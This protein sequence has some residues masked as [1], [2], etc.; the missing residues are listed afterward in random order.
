MKIMK[1]SV[2]QRNG[3]MANNGSLGIVMAAAYHMQQY[4]IM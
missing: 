2:W 4:R 3:G 1:E